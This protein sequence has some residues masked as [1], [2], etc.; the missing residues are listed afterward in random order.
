[1]LLGRT[2]KELSFP[3]QTGMTVW[4]TSWWITS[5]NETSPAS[6]PISF[7]I[8]GTNG[9]LPQAGRGRDGDAVMKIA[10]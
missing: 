5:R 10:A 3:T 7:R 1:M 4:I 2:D 9:A 6:A 8:A